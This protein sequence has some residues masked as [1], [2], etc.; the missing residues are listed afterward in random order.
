MRPMPVGTPIRCS[1]L[2]SVPGAADLA[3]VMDT[4]WSSPAGWRDAVPGARLP[5]VTAQTPSCAGPA[6]AC[7]AKSRKCSAAAAAH[8]A[9]EQ[10]PRT[11]SLHTG[12][13]TEARAAG[14]TAPPQAAPEAAAPQSPG[15]PE[16]AACQIGQSTAARTPESLLRAG[17]HSAADGSAADTTGVDSEARDGAK[18]LARS[19]SMPPDPRQDSRERGTTASA[20]GSAVDGARRT[21]ESTVNGPSTPMCAG[22]ADSA[23]DVG[24]T[25]MRP[26]PGADNASASAR[27]ATFMRTVSRCHKGF[28]KH[29]L[30]QCLERLLTTSASDSIICTGHL[31][32]VET[33][34][35]RTTRPCRRRR[36]RRAASMARRTASCP[37]ALHRGPRHGG[38]GRCGVRPQLQ[39]SESGRLL[40]QPHE[41]DTLSATVIAASNCFAVERSLLQFVPHDAGLLS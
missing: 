3:A 29:I 18:F 24:A 7:L 17:L 34:S 39:Q 30:Q 4:A 41:T 36:R 10:G 33:A 27:C 31:R 23:D 15:S 20:G 40:A 8:C 38:R 5:V 19:A 37:R 14:A 32:R 16:A 35:A 2:L 1:W 22:G 26:A 28:H 9:P 25:A 11:P 21:T 6:T 12:S 13:P